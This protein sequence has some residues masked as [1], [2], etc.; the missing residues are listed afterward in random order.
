MAITITNQTGGINFQFSSTRNLFIPHGGIGEVKAKRET[1]ST[2]WTLRVS[3]NNGPFFSF[4][5]SDVASPTT[6]DANSLANLLLI[7]NSG[8][9]NREITTASAGQVTFNVPFALGS[10]ID[11]YINGVMQASGFTWNIGGN[12]VIFATPM[13]GGEA[14]IITNH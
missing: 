8:A 5:Y 3:L 7:Y 2:R 9:S 4:K 13:T 6:V 14:V 1:G 11:V 10:S 12:A